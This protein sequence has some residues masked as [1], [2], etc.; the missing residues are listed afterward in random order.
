M[1][2]VVRSAGNQSGI[3]A[4]GAEA[5]AEIDSP[6]SRRELIAWFDRSRDLD[7]RQRH[8]RRDREIEA[9]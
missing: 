6:S 9:P 8:R 4:S 2:K 7:I 3:A 1:V 5:L